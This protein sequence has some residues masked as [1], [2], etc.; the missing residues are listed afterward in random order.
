MSLASEGQRTHLPQAVNSVGDDVTMPVHPLDEQ[1]ASELRA[2]PLSYTPPGGPE[3]LAP[4]GYAHLNRSATLVRRD[5]EDAA[6]DLFEWRMHSMAGLQVRASD[7]PLRNETVVLMRC[8]LG[9]LSLKIPCRV[10]NVVDEPRHRGF[11]YGTLPGHP[12]AGE[13]R[14][15]LEHLDDGRILFTITAYSRPASTLAKLG[16]PI[17]RAAQRFMTQRYLQAL[18]RL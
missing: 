15:H 11:T 17:S 12:E 4:S 2:A 9:A 3:G 6:R 16:G 10:L 7:I 1:Q 5:F 13:E 8:G 18:D 14:F